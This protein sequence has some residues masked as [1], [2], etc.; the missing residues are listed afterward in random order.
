MIPIIREDVQSVKG[1][2]RRAATRNLGK[3]SVI[4]A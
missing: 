2:K 4:K 1:V 3:S